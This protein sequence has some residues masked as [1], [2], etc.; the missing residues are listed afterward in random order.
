MPRIAQPAPV[1]AA[2]R[3]LDV[4][5]NARVGNAASESEQTD[6]LR[7]KMRI[8]R[9]LVALPDAEIAAAADAV[10]RRLKVCDAA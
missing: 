5:L 6:W 9:E 8:K 1:P 7:L 10:L 2:I 4:I 3:R